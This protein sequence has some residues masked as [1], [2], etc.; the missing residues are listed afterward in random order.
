ML[1]ENKRKIMNQ[2]NDMGS[3]SY[4][5]I[6]GND[7]LYESHIQTIIKILWYLNSY[8]YKG[9]PSTSAKC[10]NKK[11]ITKAKG[12]HLLNLCNIWGQIMKV[13]TYCFLNLKSH[14][15]LWL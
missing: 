12:N 7:A 8:L 13:Q 2:K 10:I 6:T 9:M 4:N 11:R 15:S 1:T 3:R 5:L 14:V